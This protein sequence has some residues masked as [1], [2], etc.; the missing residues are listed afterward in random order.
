MQQQQEEG[1]EHNAPGTHGGN[2]PRP[3]SSRAIQ[4]DPARNQVKPIDPSRQA[5]QSEPS[6]AYL[7]I[8]GQPWLE[9]NQPAA[10]AWRGF[11]L[12]SSGARSFVVAR[13]HSL[14]FP[15]R[16]T[17]NNTTQNSTLLVAPPVPPSPQH[18]GT[19]RVGVRHQG[20]LPQELSSSVDLPSLDVRTK[21]QY[22]PTNQHSHVLSLSLSPTQVDF[23]RGRCREDAHCV[24]GAAEH[25]AW[26]RAVA[27]LDQDRELHRHVLRRPAPPSRADA[28]VPLLAVVVASARSEPALGARRS[29]Q[30]AN[31]RGM[32]HT[33]HQAWVSRALTLFAR[34][35][36]RG[37]VCL[38]SALNAS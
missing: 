37:C 11:R 28:A 18:G 19:P 2:G 24:L 14:V 9:A 15:L 34:S 21:R 29:D 36:V 30:M 35:F 22:Q 3:R 32:S 31:G 8:R 16:C 17:T 23:S 6:Q 38:C 12:E 13:R 20:A 4:C 26:P 1:E 5:N 33:A 27:V 7:S 10:A 25:H